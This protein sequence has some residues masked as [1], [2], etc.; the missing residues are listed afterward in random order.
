MN[1]LTVQLLIGRPSEPLA[2]E[3]FRQQE[4]QM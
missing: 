1:A 4:L 2:Y 3:S